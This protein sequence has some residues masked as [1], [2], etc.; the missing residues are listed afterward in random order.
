[1]SPEQRLALTTAFHGPAAPA[2]H[3]LDLSMSHSPQHTLYL[4]LS[5]AVTTQR[6]DLRRRLAVTS[7]ETVA[8]LRPL[9]TSGGK[10]LV[11]DAVVPI[12]D[13]A[14]VT[15][16]EQIAAL[17]DYPDRR[18][19]EDLAYIGQRTSAW[20]AV[21][22][23]PRRWL[24]AYAETIR[25]YW[26]HLEPRW[27]S[28]QHLL[29]REVERIGVASVRGGLD[30]ALNTLDPRLRF[31]GGRFLFTGHCDIPLRGR[32]LILVPSFIAPG[33]MI[34]HGALPDVV[35]IAYAVPGQQTP[36]AATTA[37][38]RDRLAL[39]LGGRRAAVLRG[40]QTPMTMGEIARHLDVT[41]AAATRHCDHL[42]QAGLIV[43]ERRGQSVQVSAS[44]RGEALRDLLS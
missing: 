27:R 6:R 4:R 33:T 40:L 21:A 25:T 28:A 44:T 5:A 13:R 2:A 14:D 24:R 17:H 32:R 19:T 16:R 7:A 3:A 12:V 35:S 1:M 26:Q 37:G 30:A 39:V 15:V 41:P 11:P 8:A 10:G 42:E 36:S 9:Q 22:R 23:D 43:R 38:V 20:D 31:V 18:L 34:I 29:D